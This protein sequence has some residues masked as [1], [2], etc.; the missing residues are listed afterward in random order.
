MRYRCTFDAAGGAAGGTLDF[1][2]VREA[3]R[4]C[5][6]GRDL[7]TRF[8][9][10]YV[11]AVPPGALRAKGNVLDVEVTNTGSNRLRD[12]DRRGVAWKI[13][14]DINMVSKDYKPLDASKY[15]FEAAGLLG[16]VT[17][18]TGAE[19]KDAEDKM[20]GFAAALVDAGGAPRSVLRRAADGPA[21][22]LAGADGD[23]ELLPRRRRG[24]A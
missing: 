24:R 2:D 11:F 16:P 8:M 12:L 10:P 14:T 3:A 4:V 9:K 22:E 19:E 7:G 23:D 17:L 18:E 21:G 15:P 5:L 13:F 20:A 1:G 6:N